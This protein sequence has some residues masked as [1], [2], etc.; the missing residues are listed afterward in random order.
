MLRVTLPDSIHTHNMIRPYPIGDNHSSHIGNIGETVNSH[1][2]VAGHGIRL[3]GNSEGVHVAAISQPRPNY[4]NL[5][6]GYDFNAEYFPNDLIV[7]DATSSYFDQNGLPISAGSGSPS[8]GVG[9]WVCTNYIPPSSNTSTFLVSGIVP[10]Y[11]AAGGFPTDTIANSFRWYGYNI[12]YPVTCSMTQTVISTSGF[13]IQCSQS[14]W[15]P[16][17]AA[18][19]TSSIPF[20]SYAGDWNDSS[21]YAGGQI[22]QVKSTLVSGGVTIQPGTYALRPG[23]ST[24]PSPSG[25]MVPQFPLPTGG[26][27]VYWDIIAFAP[28][29]Y[30]DCGLNGTNI[31]INSSQTF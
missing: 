16:L 15:L 6:G 21:S 2:I 26:G 14:F 11:Q 10:A 19:P 20:G 17:A 1:N 24:V 12:Y 25:S 5:R 7:V 30:S 13:N 4:I 28:N 27:T 23:L 31:Y 22:V 3:T 8:I 18:A 9:T 29:V